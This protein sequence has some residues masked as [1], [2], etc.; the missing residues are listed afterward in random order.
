MISSVGKFATMGLVGG[1]VAAAAVAK[2]K[3]QKGEHA[4]N[5]FSTAMGLGAL[6]V[7][8]Y[9]VKQAA[10]INPSAVRR[11]EYYTGKGIEKAVQYTT[12]YGKKAIESQT[13]KKAISYLT[14]VFD[15]VKSTKIG[16]TV[17]NKITK[18]AKD[19]ASNKSVQN[20][21]NKAAQALKKFANSSKLGKGKMAL[22]AAGV[23]LL[24]YAGVKTIT[25]YYKKEGAIDQKYKDMK[26]MDEALA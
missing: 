8:P 18:V 19:V 1:T 3:T 4:A 12:K 17:I 6:A 14:K 16:Q 15:K 11:A 13:G 22:I 7:T 20:V 24:A 9:L 21:A 23:A 25:N 2:P 5:K 10:K 26:L